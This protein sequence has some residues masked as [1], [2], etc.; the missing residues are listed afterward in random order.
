M[1]YASPLTA[2]AVGTFAAAITLTSPADAQSRRTPLGSY[3]QSCSQI[4]FDNGRLTAQ[5][6]DTRGGTRRSTLDAAQ[7][8]R[9]DIA[10]D[11]G[12]LVCGATR[13]VEDRRG[14]DRNNSNHNGPG[15][16][17]DRGWGGPSGERASI[18]VYRDADFR[19]HYLTFTG[20]VANLRANG[21]N[22]AISSV[23][24]P[25][26]DRWEVC[27][28]ANFR[29]RCQV[30]TGDERSLRGRGLDDKISSLRPVFG[31]R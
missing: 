18:T 27:E 31:R 4:S 6:Q 29:G 24:I 22:D 30:L 20:E 5:C 1:K 15:R 21:I 26:G 16:E 12:I 2:F 3:S 11:N 8:G 28:D 23:R 17:P 10:N 14:P 7:C 19:G 25:R 13:G 9:T